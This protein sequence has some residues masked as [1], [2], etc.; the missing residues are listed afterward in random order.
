MPKD[1]PRTPPLAEPRS[2]ERWLD[3]PRHRRA[4]SWAAIASVAIAIGITAWELTPSRGAAGK[5]RTVAATRGDVTQTV[6]ANGTLNP[7]V[8]VNVG[9]QVSGTVKKL[10]VD[11][12]D[13]VKAGQVLLELDPALLEAQVRQDEANLASAKASLNLAVANEARSK[14][15]WEQD[16]IAKQ[17]LDTAV[18]A[19][20]SGEAQVKQSEAQ[21]AKDRTNLDYSVIRSPVSGVVVNRAVDLGQTVAASFQTPTL[22][23]IAQDLS[24]MQIDSSF[25]EADVGNIKI[26]QP[27]QFTVDAFPE[28]TFR[29]IVK[30]VRLNPTTVQNV[31]TYDVVVAVDNPDQ[32]LMPGMTAYVN[33]QVVQHKDVLTVPNAALRYRPPDTAEV[34]ARGKPP[35]RAEAR[36]GTVYVLEE[37][38][39]RT[40]SVQTGIS[41]GRV[42]E[43]VSGQLKAGDPVVVSAEAGP[44]DTSQGTLRLRPF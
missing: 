26:G 35:S 31:V 37:R 10:H 41:D 3:R 42:T 11:F 15:L 7:V 44:S 19:R 17:A 39:L 34:A 28:R 24:K 2:R 5:Y 14:T 33:V 9:T 27:V 22:F 40:V 8:L 21:L 32:I 20:E 6:S 29:A 12:N 16:S 43:I 25:A 23:Q 1:Q 13:R 36:S 38:Q 4:L 18:Q 30:Q